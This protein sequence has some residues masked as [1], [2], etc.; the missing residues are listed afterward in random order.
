MAG[1]PPPTSLRNKERPG[2]VSPHN[3]AVLQI[4][5]VMIDPHGS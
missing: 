5:D 2:L 3:A 4:V 1:S